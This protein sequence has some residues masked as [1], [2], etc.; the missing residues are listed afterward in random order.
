MLAV[1]GMERTIAEYVALF[2]K[3][4]LRLTKTTLLDNGY[5]VIETVVA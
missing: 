3:V 1:N 4:G 5:V 2:E